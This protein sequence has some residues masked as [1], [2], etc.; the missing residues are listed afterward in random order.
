MF[1]RNCSQSCIVSW[2]LGVSVNGWT[3]AYW[4]QSVWMDQN[5]SVLYAGPGSRQ[6]C[7][8]ASWLHSEGVIS[9][10]QQRAGIRPLCLATERSGYLWKSFSSRAFAHRRVFKGRERHRRAFALM[11]CLLSNDGE[12]SAANDTRARCQR[13]NEQTGWRHGRPT[14]TGQPRPPSISSRVV[15]KTETF[16]SHCNW[17]A[18]D[19]GA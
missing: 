11:K 6:G 13:L 10:W 8:I 2:S 14:A 1:V 9:K 3:Q 4:T 5:R 19:K 7:L 17:P 18:L 15:M 12:E 16:P